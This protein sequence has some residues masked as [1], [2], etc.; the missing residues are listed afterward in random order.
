MGAGS[1]SVSSSGPDGCLNKPWFVSKTGIKKMT[2]DD[3][4]TCCAGIDLSKSKLDA[5][6]WPSGEHRVFD[7]T[8]DGLRQLSR[9][10]VEAGVVRIGFEASGGYE[11]RLLEH[12]R[13]GDIPA[14]RP[15]PAQVKSFARSRLRR[16]KNDKLDAM[17]IAAFTA[18]LERLPGLPGQLTLELAENLTFIEQIEDQL[19]VVRTSLATTASPRL[20]RLHAAE[21][22][23]L[24]ARREA[25]LLRLARTVQASG[26]LNRRLARLCSIKG[27]GLRTALALV[28]RL[29][30]LG[31]LSR[32][33]VA[34]LTGV[35]PF[36]RDSGKSTGK[37]SVQGGRVRLRKSVFIAAFHSHQMEPRHQDLL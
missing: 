13:A 6:L 16:A 25:E 27:I 17:L 7:Y 5:A 15:Q 11:R 30:E 22:R 26:E 28:I 33:Q 4:N 20:R 37:R 12:L 18:S 8:A 14:V 9:F 1:P 19:V 32:E 2:K 29:P 10:L 23:R 35:A 34:A 31:S 24:E 36:D 3:D 21:I